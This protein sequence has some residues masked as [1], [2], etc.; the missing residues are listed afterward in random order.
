MKE[1]TEQM[2]EWTRTNVLWLKDGSLGPKIENY[3]ETAAACHSSRP[4]Q[5]AE[6][7]SQVHH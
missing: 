4:P 7:D 2:N 6:L 5:E 1:N 3:S